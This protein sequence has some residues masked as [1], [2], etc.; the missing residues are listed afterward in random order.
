MR[1]SILA[2]TLVAA[3]LPAY[4]GDWNPRLAAEYLDSREKEWSAW[5]TAAGPGGTCFSCHTNMT[6]MLAR[7]ALRAALNE[8]GPT[9]FENSL[10]DGLRARV[11]K[12]DGKEIMPA[13]GKEPI[14]SQALGVEAIFSALFLARADSGKPAMSSETRQAFDRMWSFQVREGKTAGAWA[15]FSLDLD[16]WETADSPYYGAA[17]AAVAAGSTP[18]G[19]QEQPEV[20]ARMQALT[21]Y[22]L[23]ERESQPLHNRLMLLWAAA[24]LPGVLPAATK[25]A[26][27]DEIRHKQESD[28]GWS[29]ESLGPWKQRSGAPASEGSNSYATAFTA[30]ALERGAVPASAPELKGALEWLRAHQDRESGFWEANSMNK[31]FEPGSMQVRFMRDAAT[32]F[33]A[34]ALLEAGSSRK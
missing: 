20:R 12:K 19:Y 23:R 5:R 6:Y 24:K 28:G 16:P 27:I 14:A 4:C 29:M 31:R 9:P 17:L 32:S 22:L 3:A 7:P 21:S 30:F 33:A 8:G 34:L 10:L 25:Q 15:W 26:L 1:N 11:D 18:S 2:M 13:F